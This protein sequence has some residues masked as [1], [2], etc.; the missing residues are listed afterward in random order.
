MDGPK[1]KIINYCARQNY[2][3]LN[4]GFKCQCNLCETENDNEE[5]KKYYE[6]FAKLKRQAE[7]LSSQTSIYASK[8]SFSLEKVKKEVLCY[9][10]M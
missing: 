3:L 2:L 7:L 9:K 6:K 5:N 10:E 4:W 8:E 1:L